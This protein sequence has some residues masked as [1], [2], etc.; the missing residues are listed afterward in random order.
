MPPRHT[1]T[2]DPLLKGADWARVRA[3]WVR[4]R[5]PCRRCGRQIDYTR[6]ATGDLALDVG[7][8]V[9]RDEAKAMGWTR[10][11]INALS[12]T[13][14]ECRRCSRS[15]GATYGNRKRGRE[16]PSRRWRSAERPI[17]ADEW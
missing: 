10:A 12:N 15:S 6:G 5:E 17:E 4:R 7:H 13:Q 1:P 8:I 3:H 9:G 14:P 2:G 11:Q 16:R